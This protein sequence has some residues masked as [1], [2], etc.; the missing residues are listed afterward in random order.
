MM[1]LHRL[2][3]KRKNTL[4]THL[5]Q[6]SRIASTL[7]MN[8]GCFRLRSDPAL[9]PI[10][11]IGLSARLFTQVKMLE[12]GIRGSTTIAVYHVRISAKELV[13]E[14][15]C[16]SMPMGFSSAGSTLLNIGLGYAKTV[17]VAIEEFVSLL[18][19]KKNSDPSI[20][21]PVPLFPL[22]VRAPPLLMPWTLLQ[23]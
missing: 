9:V 19:H 18:T 11:T 5:Y 1:F 22:L 4:S 15:I 8:L 10:R 21:L 16:A 7:Q 12:E 2:Y 6:T 23:P 3:Q 20:S 17:Q 13:E 14:G